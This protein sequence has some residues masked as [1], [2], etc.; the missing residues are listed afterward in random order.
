MNTF[1]A[2]GCGSFVRFWAAGVVVVLSACAGPGGHEDRERIVDTR[3]GRTVSCAELAEAVR[4]SP[5]ALL[6]E[7][8]D[9]STHHQRRGVLIQRLRGSGAVIVAEHLP[10]TGAV[11]P[12]QGALLPALQAGGFRPQAWEWPVHQPLFEA[13]ATSG[14]PLRGGDL[15]MEELRSLLRP[16]GAVPATLEALQARVVAAPLPADVQAVLDAD[17]QDAHGGTLPAAR[18]VLMRAAQRAR[19]ASMLTALQDSGGRP[20]VLVAGNGHVRGDY[21]VPQLLRAQGLA[22]LNVALLAPGQAVPGGPGIYTHV[23]T[24]DP[25][26]PARACDR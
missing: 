3:S 24:V 9:Q 18:L 23:W 6:G 8:H 20:A 11:V 17:L 2:R 25:D 22:F 21:G 10:R 13:I 4:A 15:T 7:Q 5:F 16:G 19:D 12:L 26:V 14:L 1:S